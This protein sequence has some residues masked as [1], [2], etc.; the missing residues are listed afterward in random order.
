MSRRRWGD[1][2]ARN[3]GRRQE[4]VND[5]IRR[6]VS[7][8]LERDYADKVAPMLTVTEVRTTGD[9]RHARIFVSVYAERDQQDEAIKILQRERQDLRQLLAKE[10]VLKYIPTLEFIL[11]QSQ[12]R[13][14]RIDEL[15]YGHD[16]NQKHK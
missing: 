14:R 12:E 13:A 11:D 1:P 9:L 4:R 16:E 8:I 5:L 3:P 2:L 10:V 6:Q 15:L 7:T